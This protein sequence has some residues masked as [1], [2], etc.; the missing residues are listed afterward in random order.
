M[1]SQSGPESGRESKGFLLSTIERAMSWARAGSLWYYSV[2]S[3]CCADEV[4]ETLGSRYDLE[5]FGC[6]PQVDPSQADL[7]FVS[8]MV[9]R[10][11]APHLRELYDQM[12]EPKYVIALGSCASCGGLF[13]EDRSYSGLSGVGRII[14][15]DV[16]VPGCPPRPE[17]I[18]NGLITLQEKIREKA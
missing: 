8:G 6:A 10:K 11:A 13:S 7:L 2:Q 12:L 18:M 17:A 9:S 5:R 16:H 1:S 14:P 4:L 15:V 3:G